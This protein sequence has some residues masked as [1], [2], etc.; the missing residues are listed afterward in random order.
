MLTSLY[1]HLVW[2]DAQALASIHDMP[3]SN[4]RQR[5]IAIYAHLAAAEHVWLSRIEGRTPSQPI[6]P[7]LEL[8][9]AA[10][11]ARSSAA[12][13]EA[14]AADPDQHD[15]IVDYRNSTGREFRNR[16]ADILVHVA[17]HGS[18]HRGQIALLARQ[19]GGTPAVTEYIAFMR[20]RA[21]HLNKSESR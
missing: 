21:E 17:M 12:R 18:Y 1:Q 16:I 3:V 14:I 10:A 2:A 13:L 15:R 5:A 6:W 7:S 11:L 9:A 20:E 19:G 4:D 8:D